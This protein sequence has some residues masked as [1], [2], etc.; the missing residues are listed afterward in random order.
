MTHPRALDIR[1]PRNGPTRGK[2]W[3]VYASGGFV[4]PRR[5]RSTG[6]GLMLTPLPVAQGLVRQARLLRHA[7]HA[8]GGQDWRHG[9][10]Q[11]NPRGYYQPDL[12]RRW[13]PVLASPLHE[14]TG[15]YLAADCLAPRCAG[16]RTSAVAEL[17]RFYGRD[18][19]VR[20]VLRRMQWTGRR[21]GAAWLM[22]GPILNARVTPRRV[23]LL[24]PRPGVRVAVGG[25][26]QLPGRPA[27]FAPA[28]PT[29][30]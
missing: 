25:T 3:R 16:E 24:R 2:G 4:P 19:T 21:V 10:G 15:F 13:T 14:L 5:Q 28:W 26:V 9:H 1:C 20:Q 18:R 23:P 12:I 29:A 30:S 8:C 17:A 27:R 7:G 22:T 6:S 11:E